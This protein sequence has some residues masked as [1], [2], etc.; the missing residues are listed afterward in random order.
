MGCLASRIFPNGRALRNGFCIREVIARKV[1]RFYFSLYDFVNLD[2]ESDIK[3][4]P[5]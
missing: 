2:N 3:I 4:E 1:V 5:K